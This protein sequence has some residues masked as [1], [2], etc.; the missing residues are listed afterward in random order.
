MARISQES[1]RR[2]LGRAAVLQVSASHTLFVFVRPVSMP[3]QCSMPCRR[4]PSSNST[5]W[6]PIRPQPAVG[7]VP[8]RWVRTVVSVADVEACC[9]ELEQRGGAGLGSGRDARWLPPHQRE[10]VVQR[11]ARRRASPSST[12]RKRT[13][14]WS[15]AAIRPPDLAVLRARGR[16]FAALRSSFPA[17]SQRLRAGQS[18][19]LAH[20][21]IRVRDR[22]CPP[23]VVSRARTLAGAG[24]ATGA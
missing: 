16:R 3:A 13:G 11:V 4:E 20:K 24:A 2:R 21:S 7:A 8:M 23:A 18:C 19:V 9:G 6:T 5:L 22:P 1:A 17:S 12:G 15:P 14:G 10:H